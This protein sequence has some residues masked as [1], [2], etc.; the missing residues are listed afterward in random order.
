VR[1][2]VEPAMWVALVVLTVGLA[3]EVWTVFG[4]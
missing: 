3:V 2:W 4:G 1:R